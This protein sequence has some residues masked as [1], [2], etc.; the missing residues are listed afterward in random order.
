MEFTVFVAIAVVAL[1]F[2]G[3]AMAP[4]ANSRITALQ[5]STAGSP[6]RSHRSPIAWSLLCGARWEEPML[7]Y[8]TRHT[9]RIRLLAAALT[10]LT[11][12]SCSPFAEIATP[13]SI[14]V[15]PFDEPTVLVFG[16]EAPFSDLFGGLGIVT[17]VNVDNHAR[18]AWRRPHGIDRLVSEDRR[19]I[20]GLAWSAARKE[21]LVADWNTA[22][23][24]APDGRVSDLPLRTP[25]DVSQQA[26]SNRGLWGM[27][28]LT[29][30]PDGR[31][32]FFSF[33]ARD[34]NRR[35]Y[36]DAFKQTIDGT[37]VQQITFG[38]Q[39]GR[40]VAPSP[41]GQSIAFLTFSGG[42]IG[43]GRDNALLSVASAGAAVS[44]RLVEVVACWGCSQQLRWSPVDSRI[45][46]VGSA[47]TPSDRGLWTIDADSGELRLVV[48][49]NP[50]TQGRY[51][52]IA[53]DWA[54]DGRHIVYLSDEEASCINRFSE[55]RVCDLV[56]YVVS[57]DGTG[58]PT[59]LPGE[60]RRGARVL[61]IGTSRQA[62]R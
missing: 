48:R 43:I 14:D 11:T 58:Q 20:I 21:L 26:H 40:F 52:I 12:T 59:R 45:A 31:H 62:S 10:A 56:P 32:I 23:A 57:T 38:D 42:S 5:P 25:I 50:A 8:R 4:N 35:L 29:F 34:K 17:T 36:Y 47:R 24:V 54:P 37:S 33:Y 7:R 16:A 6:L 3:I 28:H 2:V 51:G 49:S 15:L 1:P 39:Q 61:W 22:Y 19:Q 60:F 41:D 30:S 27:D 55:G 13:K 53:F 9:R 18:Y 44:R 46:F